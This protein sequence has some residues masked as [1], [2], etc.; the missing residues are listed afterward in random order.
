MIS[1]YSSCTW[2]TASSS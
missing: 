1:K 2:T